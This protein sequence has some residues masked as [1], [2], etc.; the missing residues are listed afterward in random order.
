M[1]TFPNQVG[2]HT[3]TD[4]ILEAELRA[5]G[6]PLGI[7]HVPVEHQSSVQELYLLAAGEVKTSVIGWLH[8]WQFKRASIYWVCRGPG[9]EVGAAERLHA[10]HGTTVRV[11]GDG[12]APAPSEAFK[13]LAVGLY[14]VDDASG[15]K[16]LAD[17]IK[18]LVSRH[19]AR[20]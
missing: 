11:N 3:D 1:S 9:I 6:I 13:G 16:A 19:L 18:E 2:S 17:T 12:N 5:A 8:G 7:D 20:A 10:A 4:R 15:L 14:H